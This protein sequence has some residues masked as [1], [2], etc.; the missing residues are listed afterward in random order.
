MG[1]K[2]FLLFGRRESSAL[3]V[4]EQRL[5]ELESLIAERRNELAGLKREAE[6]AK[7][8]E[9]VLKSLRNEVNT[10][11]KLSERKESHLH[12]LERDISQRTKA[13]G[14]KEAFIQGLKR[15]EQ[16]LRSSIADLE[17]AFNEKKSALNERQ[18]AMLKLAQEVDALTRKRDEYKRLEVAAKGLVLKNNQMQQEV[19]KKERRVA[20]GASL[21]SK[22]EED[23]G[24]RKQHLAELK[25]KIDQAIVMKRQLDADVASAKKS[26]LTAEREL[27][28]MEDAVKSVINTKEQLERKSVLLRDRE[29]RLADQESRIEQ[30]K[31][32]LG[33][34]R[35]ETEGAKKSR[36]ELIALLE[37]KKHVLEELKTAIVQNHQS[38]KELH[39]SEREARK[40]AQDLISAQS[41]SDKKLKLLES[42]E[43]ELMRREAAIVDHDKALKE[44]AGML[45]K[46]K[47]EF[48]D[49][50]NARKAELLLLRQE[51]EK[52]FKEFQGEKSDLQREK[53]DVRKLVES[54]VLALK[55]KEDE[56]VE[57]IAMLERDKDK[58]QA[59]EKSLLKSIS[60]LE[61][62]KDSLEREKQT[63]ASKEKRVLGG[64]R[65]LQK[66]IKFIDD[67]KR[68]IEKEKD[69]IYRARELKKILPKMEQRYEELRGSVSKTEARLMEVGTRP[70]AIRTFKER[71]KE[72]QMREKGV[73]M[74]FKKLIEKEGEVEALEQRKERA[75][76][77]YLREEVER[78]QLGKPG[79]E[80]P[81]P[82][83]HGMIDDAR[84]KVMRG[85]IDEAVLVL[86]QAEF[87]VDKLQNQE[88]RR[89]F[90]YD[91]RDLKTSIKLASLT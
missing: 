3:D 21:L 90:M 6:K 74:E 19:A 29:K 82:E 37:D 12:E 9:Q 16:A 86:S 58:L 27:A 49:E 32:E 63:I 89:L 45:G 44:A 91:I 55:D 38:I 50:V 22:M 81:N 60:E 42:R 87:L 78:A 40:S 10:R 57:A 77:E 73:H 53:F 75:F 43:K 76:S 79:R 36:Q 46:D 14:D 17:R 20:D 88:Q 4:K 28:D 31:S 2:S 71:E 64:E 26:I 23:V 52:K 15:E 68:K 72:L 1:A 62:V 83:I 48:A 18:N 39:E 8:E 35:Q 61:K 33:S 69:M 47:K 85:N 66:G 7:K 65:V 67:E 13:L 11:I 70:S 59:E 25:V 80:S 54:D 51:W 24:E 34:L 84:E 56:L 41:E 5:K 30:K